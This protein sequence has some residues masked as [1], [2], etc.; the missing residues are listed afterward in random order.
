MGKSL[1]KEAK[2]E[3]AMARYTLKDAPHRAPWRITDDELRALLASVKDDWREGERYASIISDG[4]TGWDDDKSV[5]AYSGHMV[6]E[7][8]KSPMVRALICLAPSLA[9]EVLELRA[10]VARLRAMAEDN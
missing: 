6:C 2:G 1:D 3:I 7:S 9:A 5:E 4:D 8:V 10:E